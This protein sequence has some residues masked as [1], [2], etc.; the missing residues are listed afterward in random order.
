MPENL[1]LHILYL[2][3]TTKKPNI[4]WCFQGVK[5]E[6]LA[7]NK[8]KSPPMDLWETPEMTVSKFLFLFQI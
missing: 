5:M 4:F 1:Y 6:T 3:K 2:L 8:F 7:R